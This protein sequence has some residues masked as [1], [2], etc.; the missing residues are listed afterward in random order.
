MRRTRGSL[1][2]HVITATEINLVASQMIP[3]E[4]MHFPY[5]KGRKILKSKPMMDRL[6]ARLRF[7]PSAAQSAY[8]QM[9]CPP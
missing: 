2:N 8:L 6:L 5:W 4:Y 3:D 7:E 9:E 1:I